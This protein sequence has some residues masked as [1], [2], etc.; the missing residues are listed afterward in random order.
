[1]QFISGLHP[2]LNYQ[3]MKQ[4]L[5]FCAVLCLSAFVH[6]QTPKFDNNN[7][8]VTL[9]PPVK[10]KVSLTN[11]KLLIVY[12]NQE[13]PGAT[14]Q[15]LDSLM[16]KVPDFKNVK[17]EFEGINAD[18]EIKKAVDAVLKQCKCRVQGHMI[19]KSPGF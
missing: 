11:D 4:L 3:L 12:N 8:S 16:K 9:E 5:L 1:M 7:K 6:G 19:K 10:L 13:I 2:P 14:V 18:M 15:V 17:V